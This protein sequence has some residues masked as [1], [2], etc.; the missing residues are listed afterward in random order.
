MNNFSG[1]ISSPVYVT[2]SNVN[3]ILIIQLSYDDVEQ[4]ELVTLIGSHN[5][6]EIAVNGANTQQQLG[7]NWGDHLTISLS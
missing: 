5:G 6:I 2:S 3:S 1:S 7:I 4:G